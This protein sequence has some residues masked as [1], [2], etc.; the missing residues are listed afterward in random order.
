MADNEEEMDFKRHMWREKPDVLRQRR[1]ASRRDAL[2]AA[3]AAAA[4][5]AVTRPSAACAGPDGGPTSLQ[6]HA[7]DMAFGAGGWAID[8]RHASIEFE[9]LDED[10][11]LWHT[12]VS[13]IV[14]LR[15]AGGGAPQHDDVAYAWG[16]RSDRQRARDEALRFA[17]EH[18]RKRCCAYLYGVLPKELVDRA[19]NSR[20]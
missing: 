20:A 1:L 12:G 19:R 2:A 3:A 10:T 13:V 16:R 7:L 4:A 8:L 9:T 15:P 11:G 14:R 17:C 5:A 18:A 6:L